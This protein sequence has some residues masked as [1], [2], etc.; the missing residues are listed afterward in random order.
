MGKKMLFIIN[1]KAGKT[2]VRNEFVNIVDIFTKNG[3]EVSTYPT[4]SSGD[5]KN[6]TGEKAKDYDLVVCSGGDGTMNEVV[7][8]MMESEEKVPIGYI[9]TGSTND[10]AHSL[11]IPKNKIKAANVIMEGHPFPC[12]VGAFNDAYFAYVAAFGI[13]TDVPYQTKQ[14]VKNVLGYPAYILEGMKRLNKLKSYKL[15]FECNKNTLTGEF[16]L[17]M[18]TNSISIAGFKNVDKSNIHLDD[19]LFEVTLIRKPHN[20]IE[21]QEIISAVLTREYHT[22]NLLS[23]KTDKIV[24][25]SEEE[26]PWTLDGEFG[27][28]HTQVDIEN[29]KQAVEFL[30]PKEDL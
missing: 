17:G 26:I 20:P 10:F 22:K 27:G 28:K 18:I 7:S 11:H 14:G 24:F 12:D 13:F 5:A 29:I 8:G 25:S 2:Q 23:F 21:L 9:Q 15:T 6:V 3:Y 4:Q 1:P 16:I 19:G 30:V